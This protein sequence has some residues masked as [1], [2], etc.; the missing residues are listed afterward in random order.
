[1]NDA[2]WLYFDT[3]YMHDSPLIQAF[4]KLKFRN[5]KTKN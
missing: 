5:N 2:P 1:M 4:I 3:I